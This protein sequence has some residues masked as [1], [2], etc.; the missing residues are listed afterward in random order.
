M[1]NSLYE[2]EHYVVH[3]TRHTED[4]DWR[5]FDECPEVMGA[6]YFEHYTVRNKQTNVVE[7]RTTTLPAA[8]S[9]A[10]E[11]SLMMETQPWKWMRAQYEAPD[12]PEEEAAEE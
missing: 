1:E 11:L 8:I 10:E 12:A 5:S 4:S 9:T 3:T 6:T 7:H 2:N